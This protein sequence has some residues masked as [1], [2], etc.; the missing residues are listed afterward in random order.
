M[1]PSID[2]R[3]DENGIVSILKLSENFNRFYDEKW[4][5]RGVPTQ[6]F[7]NQYLETR[8]RA[9]LYSEE[10]IKIYYIEFRQFHTDSNIIKDSYLFAH[11]M[12]HIIRLYENKVLNFGVRR[13][14]D[15]EFTP[16]FENT[17]QH[18]FE[19]T[20]VD[21]MLCNKYDFNLLPYYE[22]I[23]GYSRSNL[24]NIKKE[25]EGSERT[26]LLLQL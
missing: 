24:E 11:E 6:W 2:K 10:S 7:L 9:C 5:L 16:I 15:P 21:R 4:K 14:Y 8:A 26:A 12:G 17:L 25:P 19:D 1:L 18:I 22:E 13:L 23:L 20:A 3:M